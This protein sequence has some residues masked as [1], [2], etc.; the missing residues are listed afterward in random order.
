M[1]EHLFDLLLLLLLALALGDA[2]VS[3]LP[4]LGALLVAL[5][6]RDH[7]LEGVDTL[8]HAGVQL[9]LHCMEM[10]VDVLSKAHQHAQGLVHVLALQV[11]VRV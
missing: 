1:H 7:T 11:V 6:H 4:V 3:F 2:D 9:R 5:G 10:V 8:P